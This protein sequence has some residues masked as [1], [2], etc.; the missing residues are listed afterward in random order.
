MRKTLTSKRTKPKLP[1]RTRGTKPKRLSLRPERA[2][3]ICQQWV[4]AEQKKVGEAQTAA[5]D[6]QHEAEKA[7]NDA[8]KSASDFKQWTADRTA[9]FDKEIDAFKQKLVQIY[10]RDID[11]DDAAGGDSL[12][13][14]ARSGQGIQANVDALEKRLRVLE[15]ASGRGPESS[16]EML[17]TLTSALRVEQTSS[18]AEVVLKKSLPSGFSKHYDLKFSI[19]TQQGDRCEDHGL[20][21]IEK[22]VYRLDPRWFS[23]PNET[24]SNRA[25][26]FSFGVRVWGVTTVTACI[27]LKGRK[28]PVVRRGP[29]SL[30]GTQYWAPDPSVT[31]SACTI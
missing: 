11:I 30:T 27:Y 14:L 25:D 1:H 16:V 10:G 18:A 31:Q 8:Q 7:Q 3:Q 24:R 26:G 29:I 6:A 19:C 13:N 2:R 4:A 28:E 12:V 9:S 5:Q 15:L 21:A 23:N 22:V 20:D 17:D